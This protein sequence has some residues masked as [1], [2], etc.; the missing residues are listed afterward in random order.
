MNRKNIMMTLA[1][2]VAIGMKAQTEVAAPQ[3]VYARQTMS[4]NGEWNYFVDT[5]EQGYYDYRMNPTQWGYF[6]NAKPKSP[7]DLVEYDFDACPTLHVPGDWNILLMLR[8]K[9]PL[10]MLTCTVTVLKPCIMVKISCLTMQSHWI[11]RKTLILVQVLCLVL[12]VLVSLSP[13]RQ[14]RLFQHS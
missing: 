13:L 9:F 14:V 5:Q 1:F 10:Q 12:R 2:A 11:A 7:S 8:L 3:N 6:I 4:L